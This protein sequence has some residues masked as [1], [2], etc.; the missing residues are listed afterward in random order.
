M[1][2]ELKRVPLNFSWPMNTVWKGFLNDV[3]YRP[4]PSPSCV[5]GGTA[6]AHALECFA[7]YFAI[8]ATNSVERPVDFAPLKRGQAVIRNKNGYQQN[9]PHPYLTEMGIQDVGPGFKDLLEKLIGTPFKPGFGGYDSHDVYWALLKKLEL[10]ERWSVCGFCDGHSIHPDDYA[11]YDA[12][13][14]TEPPTG[15]G[16]QIWETVS[17]G[18]PISPVFDTPEKLARWM[19]SPAHKWE[20]DRG[21]TYESW[22]KFITRHGW[23]PSMVVENGTI[24][25]GVEA[26]TEE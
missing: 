2:R 23:A 20:T 5:N 26:M 6:E 18:S 25:S 17:E 4:C 7:R 12:W 14:A 1:G 9:Y 22:L 3:T 15:D 10:P 16:Y 13:K 19:A 21:T 8:A 24:K 11:A